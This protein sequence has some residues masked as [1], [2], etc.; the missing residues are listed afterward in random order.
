MT[1]TD[2]EIV[3]EAEP[4]GAAIEYEWACFKEAETL[5]SHS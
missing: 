5:V 3:I 4:S 2:A 1:D